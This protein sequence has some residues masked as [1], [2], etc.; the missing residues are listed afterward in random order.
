MSGGPLILGSFELYV[1]QGHLVTAV[2]CLAVD[3]DGNLFEFWPEAN[4]RGR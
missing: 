3:D 1:E 2:C 4:D